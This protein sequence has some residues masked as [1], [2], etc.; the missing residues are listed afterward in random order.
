LSPQRTEGRAVKRLVTLC[1]AGMLAAGALALGQQLPEPRKQFGASVTGAFEGW[2]TNADGSRGFLVGYYNRNSRQALDVP[3]GPDNRIE[4]G[5]PDM[6]QPTHFLPGRQYGMFVVP[7][8]KTFGADDRLTW[9]IVANGQSTS[10]PLR[11]HPDYSIEPFSE[12]AVGNTPPAIRFEERGP[13]VQGPIARLA[14][15]S[16][17]R[18]ASM[19][20]P[21][22][23]I[24]WAADDMKYTSGTGAPI[25]TARPP[26]VVTWSKYRGKGDVVFDKA[27]PAVEK[28]ADAGGAA[29]SGKATAGATFSA[30]GEYVLHV[31]A[32]D[33][34]GDGGGGFICCWTTAMMKVSVSPR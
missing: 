2:F 23:L 16:T 27:R 15:S 28:L 17:A 26:V 18:T 21:L 19:L 13:S 33:Y 32:N 14:A 4:P 3:I 29:F 6:G 11:L 10:I 30:P 1:A 12:V 8:P 9:T 31:I 7:V 34:S 24:L 25:T 5:G 22:A 20:S